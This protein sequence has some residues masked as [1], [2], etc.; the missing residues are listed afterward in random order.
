MQASVS[1]ARMS[2]RV[3]TDR[4]SR[5]RC[6]HNRVSRGGSAHACACVAPA[7][8]PATPYQQASGFGLREPHSLSLPL[9]HPF[10]SL[11]CIGFGLVWA[12]VYNTPPSPPAVLP[13]G[14][15]PHRRQLGCVPQ[16]EHQ[17]RRT[18][19]TAAA[20]GATTATNRSYAHGAR[21]CRQRQL[22]V[23]ASSTGISGGAARC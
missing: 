17:L 14:E 11:L 21:A 20:A 15:G 5:H 19:H 16:H 23:C 1:A 7:S 13:L 6:A 10:P 8:A 2:V 9:P 12:G 4:R 22:R 3:M 18:Q